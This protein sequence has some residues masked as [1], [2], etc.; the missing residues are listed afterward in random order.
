MAVGGFFFYF[1]AVR[2]ALTEMLRAGH[3]RPAHALRARQEVQRLVTVEIGCLCLREL[4][5]RVGRRRFGRPFCL[6][7]LQEVQTSAA[8]GSEPHWRKRPLSQVMLVVNSQGRR[9]VV[10]EERLRRFCHHKKRI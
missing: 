2:T 1:G 3:R 8:T 6:A 4:R 7:R 9:A 10:L 5:A